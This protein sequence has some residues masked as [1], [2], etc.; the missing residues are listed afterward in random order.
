MSDKV[1]DMSGKELTE[2]TAEQIPFEAET[3]LLNNNKFKTINPEVFHFR[4]NVWNIDL[5]YNNL[6][7]LMFIKGYKSLGT[8]NLS[9]NDLQLDD[10]I[11]I[12]HIYTLHIRIQSN[13][14]QKYIFDK[15]LILPA[16]LDRVWI[17]DGVFISDFMKKQAK[18]FKESIEY[19]EAI[20]YSR[21]EQQT[22]LLNTGA[23]QAANFIIAGSSFQ[24]DEPGDFMNSKGILI[25]SNN[26]LPQINR[27]KHLSKEFPLHLE[28]GSFIDY[29]ALALGI[30]SYMWL[31]IPIG[32]VPRLLS[33]GYWGSVS[34]EV[35]KYEN[36]EQ[37][38]LLLNIALTISPENMIQHELFEG[39]GILKFLQ[40][41][42]IPLVGSTS[43]LILG[44]ILS[45]SEEDTSVLIDV[46]TYQKFRKTCDFAPPSDEINLE[47]IHKEVIAPL[48]KYDLVKLPKKGDTVAVRH[49]ITDKWSQS[50]IISIKNGRVYTKTE[51]ISGID[52]TIVQI[53][54]MKVFYDGHN[55]VWREAKPT[56]DNMN[57]RSQ[58]ELT[59]TFVTF[60]EPPRSKSRT[61]K[62]LASTNPMVLIDPL[63]LTDAPSQNESTECSQEP[64]ETG[65]EYEPTIKKRTVE[66]PPPAI[67]SV[68]PKDPQFLLKTAKNMLSTSKFIDRKKSTNDT[69]RGIGDPVKPSRVAVAKS[70]P[71]R[72][73]NQF[74]QDVVNI[75]FGPDIGYGKKLRKFHVRVENQLTHRSSYA[76]IAEDEIPIEDV[77]RLLDLYRRH[78]EA[79]YTIIPGL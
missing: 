55:S 43:R 21:K 40:S 3:I 37:M 48:P 29:F 54:A 39:S 14:M 72:Q 70:T 46:K 52:Q 63:V 15:P 17:I 38:I 60:V 71:T 31:E 75:I 5:S 11:T 34:E 23:H 44:A 42:E 13:G 36:Y 67:K 16:L 49:P 9:Y 1:V 53:P 61:I 66:L 8:L 30:V 41:G 79:R 68:M 22:F 58:S 25:Q 47:E 7:D 56:V 24:F 35:E 27:L 32:D 74:V 65:S 18:I 10:L 6:K 69:F 50:K 4:P 45:R 51:A 19:G 20:K 62:Q 57:T 2:I 28:K 59:Q 78:I 12:A 33:R 26:D 77:Q 73:P 76:W 64:S